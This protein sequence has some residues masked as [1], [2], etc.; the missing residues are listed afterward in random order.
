M[1]KQTWILPV[2]AV[3][4]AAQLAVPAS[5][6]VSHE[7]T[8][9]NGQAVKFRTRPVD[10]ADFM[11]GHYVWLGLEPDTV[12]VPEP[13]RWRRREKAYAILGT[14]E[15]GFATV[16]R[17]ERSRPADETAIRVRTRWPDYEKGEIHISWEGLDRYYMEESKAPA[18]ERA[19]LRHNTGTNRTC[20]VTVR[21]HSGQAVIEELYIEDQPVREWLRTQDGG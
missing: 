5:M 14:D 21:V 15:E 19:Y 13:D 11:R 16:T 8:L 12:K 18:A 3:V 4:V 9:R 20:H 17:L 6:I 1:S 2:F 10:P 7:R